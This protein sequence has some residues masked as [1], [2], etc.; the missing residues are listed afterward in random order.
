MMINLSHVYPQPRFPCMLPKRARHIHFSPPTCHYIHV[1]SSMDLDVIEYCGIHVIPHFKLYSGTY[2]SRNEYCQRSYM[3]DLWIYYL[4]N[5]ACQFIL[6]QIW[7]HQ[8]PHGNIICQ[9]Q[10]F[11]TI[12]DLCQPFTKNLDEQMNLYCN[13]PGIK[14]ATV[15]L[16]TCLWSSK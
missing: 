7:G 12:F 11:I 5:F 6:N 9:I 16:M 15:C 8:V 2:L 10:T 4:T 14:I 13:F 1:C 3:G